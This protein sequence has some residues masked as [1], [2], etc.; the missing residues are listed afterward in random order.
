MEKIKDFIFVQVYNI[1]GVFFIIMLLLI[2]L[3]HFFLSGKIPNVVTY[4]FWLSSG[5]YVGCFWGVEA[6]RYLR[7]K[8]NDT[9]LN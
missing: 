3:Y 6:M 9:T 5:M 8:K 2:C 4:L 1:S 7:K